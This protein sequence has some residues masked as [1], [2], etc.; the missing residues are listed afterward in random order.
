MLSADKRNALI[1]KI[2]A[3]PRL[4]GMVISYR[5]LCDVERIISQGDRTSENY[6]AGVIVVEEIF[7]D[8]AP[9]TV[10]PGFVSN[11]SALGRELIGALEEI[12]VGGGVVAPHLR[13]D[14][15][16]GRH[17]G[18]VPLAGPPPQPAGAQAGGLSALS[19][20][21]PA[22]PSTRTLREIRPASHALLE[23]CG[24]DPALATFAVFGRDWR[25]EQPT[26]QMK[27]AGSRNNAS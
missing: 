23:A 17:T 22:L 26:P 24:D 11:R 6:N 21:T 15:V 2:Y 14:F 25:A 5:S 8:G 9:K 7:G 20:L 13:L 10:D 27:S 1:K 16:E 4:K 19:C 3:C 12:E 18:N